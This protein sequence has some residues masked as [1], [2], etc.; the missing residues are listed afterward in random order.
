MKRLVWMLVAL[1]SFAARDA[2]AQG[3]ISP[4]IGMTLTSPSPSGSSSKPGFGVA[5]GTLG[6]I[7]GFET[8]IAYFPELLDNSASGLAKNRVFTFSGNTLIG[9][10]IG[11]VKAYGAI[12]AGDLLLNVQSLSS[13]VI[14]NPTSTTSNYFMFNVGGGVMGFFNNH[15]GVRGDLR[16]YKAYGF[17]LAA[18]QTSG[19]LVLDHFDFWRAS[20]GLAAKF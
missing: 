18:T 11:P 6:G 19:Q 14:P 13:V 20:I 16:Y 17:D 1:T 5:L 10:M 4:F 7:V 12:G 8:D 2:S 15:L 3:F 9:P